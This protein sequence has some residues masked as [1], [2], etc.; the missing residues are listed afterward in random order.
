MKISKT[1]FTLLLTLGVL[2]SACNEKISPELQN[3]GNAG[4][5]GTGTL[6]PPEEYFFK[7]ENNSKD[8]LNYHL[9]R[10]GAGNSYKNCEIKSSTEFTSVR[11]AAEGTASAG[12]PLTDHDNKVFDITCIFEAEELAL[13][14]SGLDFK[15]SAS[16]NTCEYIGYSP[17]SYFKYLPGD[18]SKYMEAKTAANAGADCDAA[19]G[20]PYNGGTLGC[21]LPGETFFVDTGITNPNSRA[22]ITEAQLCKFD[23]TASGGPNCDVGVIEYNNCTYT[24]KDDGTTDPPACTTEFKYCGGEI[25]NCIGGPITSTELSGQTR[26]TEIYETTNNETFSMDFSL[27]GGKDTNSASNIGVANFRRDL[28]AFG[29]DFGI[30]TLVPNAT[31]EAADFGASFIASVFKESVTA[32][33]KFDPLVM[34]R[35]SSGRRGNGNVNSGLSTAQS[36]AAITSG[37]TA[38]PLAA[39]PFLGIGSGNRTSPFYTFYCF[40]RAYEVKARIRMVVREWDR[41]FYP[42]AGKSLDKFAMISDIGNAATGGARIHNPIGIE[43]ETDNEVY[44]V[45]NDVVSW[46]D[47]LFMERDNATLIWEPASGY[48]NSSNFPGE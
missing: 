8:F 45:Y 13:Y 18:S 43:S 16:Q 41:V 22:L 4:G 47:I 10:T 30:T 20:E 35:Y 2:A 9:H 36:A 23:Y 42:D 24:L 25:S 32:N 44:N 21:G 29:L 17:Y 34:D 5:G 3:S 46:E 15:F 26:G 40:D 12:V 19:G 37:H 14:Y 38:V 33:K 31:T 1:H 28:S 6:V 7:I 27:A 11:Y 39:D 48:F